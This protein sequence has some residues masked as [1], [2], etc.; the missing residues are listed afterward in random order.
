[1]QT[2]SGAPEPDSAPLA[3]PADVL[4]AH[5]RSENFPVALR[6]LPRRYR[7][8]LG[9]VYAFAR[10]VDEIGDSAIGDRTEALR[11]VDA[12]IDRTW[13][14][15]AVADPVLAG[16]AAT[17]VEHG[18]PAEPFHRLVAANVQDQLIHRYE[19]FADLRGYCR[20]SADPVGRIVLAVFGQASP[21]AIE[22]SDRV[23]T[24]LQLLE[25]WQDVAEDR[26]AGRVYLPLEDLRA[27]GV[28]EG[29]LDR[30][31]AGPAVTALLRFE[32]DRAA[33]LLEDGSGIVHELRGWARV[34]VA[35]F[36]A[37]GRATV[38]ALGRTGGDV[39]SRSAV[40][41]TSGTAARLVA[42][43]ASATVHDAVRWCRS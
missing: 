15:D 18:V 24:A 22:L 29:D 32:I 10:G 39:L 33:R 8:D 16:L 27:F 38:A 2:N 4:W 21:T 26:R 7:E 6:L 19:T 11:A 31:R 37:G 23:C 13:A 30:P 17:V 28:E 14:G 9:A 34:S 12:D 40:P 3:I 20:L 42:L 5:E 35:G 25:H 41:S 43:L 36:V 1:M